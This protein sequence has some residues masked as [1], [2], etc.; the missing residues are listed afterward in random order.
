MSKYDNDLKNWVTLNDA[1]GN[2]TLDKTKKVLA[3]EQ[4]N[5]N[6]PTFIRRLKQRINAL[7][8]HKATVYNV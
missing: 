1:I 8:R 4:S 7:S 6:R 3:Y 5:K 2:Y